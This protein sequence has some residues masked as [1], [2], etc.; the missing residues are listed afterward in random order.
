MSSTPST[1]T[2]FAYG[3]KLLNAGISGI[4]AGH[5]SFNPELATALITSSAEESLKLAAIGMG[6]G[7]LPAIIL[8]RGRRA[9]SAVVFGALGGALGFCAGFSWRT[10]KLTSSLAHSAIHEVQ[11]VKD[12][13]W[14]ETHPIDFA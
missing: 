1:T 14:L 11:R 8:R 13:H 12:E 9:T 5:Q 10:R 7:V 6:L 2:K 4:H 3:R